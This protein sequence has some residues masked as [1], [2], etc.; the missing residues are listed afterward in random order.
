MVRSKKSKSPYHQQGPDS[1]ADSVSELSVDDTASIS[2][3]ISKSSAFLA[4][5][6]R[7]KKSKGANNGTASVGSAS[8]KSRASAKSAPASRT[9]VGGIPS[10][11]GGASV[12]SARSRAGASPKTVS[13]NDTKRLM[14][15]AKSRFNIGLVYLKTGD[16]SK[17]QDNLEHS[18]YCHIQLSG[19]DSKAYT[20]DALV[21]IAGVREKLGDCYLANSAI[22]DKC[23]ALDHYEESR[24]LLKSIAKEDAPENVQEMLDRVNERL[25]SPELCNSS[26]EMRRRPPTVAGAG[27]YQMQGNDKAKKMLGVGA[28]AGA[29]AAVG[30]AT[31]ANTTTT[32]NTRKEGRGKTRIT[33]QLDVLGIGKG[34]AALGAGIKELGHDIKEAVEDVFDSESDGDPSYHSTVSN[35]EAEGFDTA[36]S[37][38]ERDNHRTALNYL[39]SPSFME[40][41]SIKSPGF[42]AEM[43]LIMMKIGD[44]ALE[45]EKIGVAVDAYE[46][47]YSILQEDEEMKRSDKLSSLS[48][49]AASEEY[50]LALRG[51]IKGHKLLAM[52]NES[53][54]SF[55]A[56]IEHRTRLYNLLDED[57]RCI[58][59]CQQ[60][61]K[62][63]YL[64]GEKDDYSKS[65]VTL[66]D[67]IRRLYKGVNS[68]DMMPADRVELL[69]TCY[70]MKAICYAKCK[71]WREAL[72]VYDDLLPLISK[73]EGQGDKAYNSALI[74]KSALL[75]TLGNHRLA[76][77]TV[78]K[79]LQLS[80]LSDEMVGELIV[81]DMDHVLALD[82][83]AATHLKLGNVDKAQTIFEKKLS[84]VKA[85]PNNDEMKSDTMHKLGC[86][87][88]YK[89]EHKEA[90]PLLSE[91]LDTRKFLYDGKSPSVF[92]ST[93]AVAA[94]SQTIGDTNRALKEYAILLEKMNQNKMNDS[95]VDLVLIHNSA[96]KLFFDEGKM[97]K[98]VHSFRQ[99]LAGSDTH[100]N[101]QLKAEVTLNLANALSARGEHDKAMDLYDTLLS[102][103]SLKRTKMFFLTL[104]NKSLLLIKMGEVE[105][106]RDILDKVAATR[107][108]MADDVRGSIYLALGNLSISEGNFKEALSHFDNALDA[109][110]DGDIISLAHVKR[111]IGNAHFES[112]QSDKAI[113]E[114]DD[115]L[116]DLSDPTMEGG[117]AVE[118]L[119]A[120]VWNCLSRVYRKKGD[121]SHATHYAKL[122]KYGDIAMIFSSRFQ[123]HLIVLHFLSPHSITNLQIRTG[124]QESY[125]TQKCVQSSTTF[126]GRCRKYGKS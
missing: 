63:A 49:P 60:L 1:I 47:A 80:E 119:R 114:F 99:A 3:S 78:N 95:P 69:I 2:S 45:S 51:C 34:V 66:S 70:Q 81:D 124:R 30:G 100:H 112:G 5:F 125:H 71:K 109:V 107:S 97:D 38:L 12:A 57:N 98:S 50:K 18:L 20:N 122:G 59:A 13:I 23:L 106:A 113:A 22:V 115:V 37:H 93:W 94:A 103:K 32:A 36:M 56:A 84:F 90:M 62:V 75:V 120:E 19:H 44:S 73:T 43:V 85:L 82:T 67:A 101:P 14:K 61:V 77:T 108:S 123:F 55:Q 39:T 9:A 25:K 104:Y 105:E 17:A 79:Y 110:E 15:D 88:A 76:S 16:Y 8:K 10:S 28:G 86:L 53:L 111:N 33:E 72:D 102:T 68:L 65:L 64:Y 24:R 7:N 41:G 91:A 116:E 31:A 21:A 83:A 48:V 52:E 40:G 11:P 29:A 27:K 96:G 4:K 35:E 74:Q 89:K 54:H 117:K 46:E 121:L 118:L 92:E 58:P 126:I 42:R 87:L 6:K 26:G